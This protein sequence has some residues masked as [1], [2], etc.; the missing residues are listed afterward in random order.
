MSGIERGL[1]RGIG[2]VVTLLTPYVLIMTSVRMLMSHTFLQLEYHA[3]GFPADLYGFTLADRLHWG[4]LSVDYLINNAGINF[5]SDLHFAN[6]MPIYNERELS[7]MHDVKALVQ[8]TLQLW[9]VALGIL[10]VLA[11]VAVWRKWGREYLRG[12]S[13]GGWLTVGIIVLVLA[14]VGISF[15]WLFTEFHHLFFTG[16]T[17]LFYY[18]DTLIR[19]FPMRFWEDGFILMGIFCIVSGLI[20]G[21]VLRPGKA[22]K[23]ETDVARAR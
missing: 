8:T 3:P 4:G 7:H 6:G 16:N 21:I 2:W 13:R 9:V 22:A 20:L 23:P 11:A 18:S 10:L 19:L 17:W 5:L 12:L 15:D 14:G 1:S